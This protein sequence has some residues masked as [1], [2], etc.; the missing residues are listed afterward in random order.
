MTEPVTDGVF[1]SVDKEEGGERGF[2][3][4]QVV[5]LPTGIEQRVKSIFLLAQECTKDPEMVPI[6]FKA[7]VQAI[8][9]PMHF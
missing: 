9:G 4:I 3:K 7:M 2:P 8:Y 5:H 6:V 1:Y